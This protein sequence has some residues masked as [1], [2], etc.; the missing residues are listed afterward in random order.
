MVEPTIMTAFQLFLLRFLPNPDR[1]YLL[2]GLLCTL[3]F[4]LQVFKAIWIILG[5]TRFSTL[6]Q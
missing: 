6:Q 4:L 3:I 1:L 5:V 2:L